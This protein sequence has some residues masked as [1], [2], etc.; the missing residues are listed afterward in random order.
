MPE[1][2]AEMVQALKSLTQEN[3]DDTVTLPMA[4]DEWYTRPDTVSYG[5]VS[6]DFEA[7]QLNGD[8]L[9][10][11][12]SYEGSVDLFSMV[13]GGAGWVQKITDTLTEYTGSCWSLNSHTYE[14]DTGL[15]HWEWTFEVEN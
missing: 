5:M 3:E 14:R 10:R 15:F 2:Y 11:D 7:G 4:E 13:R 8:N 12:V 6:L 9:K 1:K